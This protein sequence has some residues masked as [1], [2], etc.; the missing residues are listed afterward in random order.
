MVLV[1]AGI[2]IATVLLIWLMRP[3]TVGVQGGGGIFNRQPRMT[4]LVLL[5]AA[6]VG[7]VVFSVL[8]RRHPPRVGTRGA[9]AIGSG[10]AIVLAV[11]AGILWPGGVIHH[12]PPHINLPPVADTSIPSSTPTTPNTGTAVTT[13]TTVSA[14]TT[15]T[16]TTVKAG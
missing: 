14:P 4:L 15:A 8:G 13:P 5:T 12:W 6:A 3:G 7:G 11:V 1:S 16:P 10:A 2:V 9:I